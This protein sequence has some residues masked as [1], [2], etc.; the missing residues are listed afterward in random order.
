MM[1]IT[2][3]VIVIIITV[4]NSKNK[5]PNS[6][7]VDAVAWINEVRDHTVNR[8][9]I[10]IIINIDGCDDTCIV[11]YVSHIATGRQFVATE[12]PQSV[13]RRYKLYAFQF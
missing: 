4:T 9:K 6:F 10:T 11:P 13:A 2:I 1:I 8:F 5:F 3:I 12:T 7:S